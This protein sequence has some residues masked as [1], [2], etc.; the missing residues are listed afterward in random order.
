MEKKRDKNAGNCRL[1][2]DVTFLDLGSLFRAACGCVRGIKSIWLMHRILRWK[3]LYKSYNSP[4]IKPTELISK[5]TKRD[6]PHVLYM[7]NFWFRWEALKIKISKR[8]NMEFLFCDLEPNGMI[9]C[10]PEKKN[11]QRIFE[12]T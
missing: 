10:S 8:K 7:G 3:V 2:A 6:F 1:R 11:V 9:R 5:T 12:P 4:A